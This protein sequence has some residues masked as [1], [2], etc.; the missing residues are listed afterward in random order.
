MCDRCDTPVTVTGGILDFTHGSP[1]ALT[2]PGEYDA[3]HQI[4]DERSAA[5]YRDL[6]RLA[7]ERW[8]TSL[9]SVLEVGCGTGLLTRGLVRGDDAIDLTATD[10]SLPMLLATRGHLERAGLLSNIPVT[11]AAHDGTEPVF[12]D[13]IFDTA[14]GTSVLHH[15]TDVRGFLA[16]VF[17]WLK[18]GGRAF[19]TEP[20]LRYHR[21]L[22]QTL[23]D[24]IAIM[25]RSDPEFSHGRQTLL[26]L[27][28]QWRQGILHQNDLPFLSGLD[29]KHMFASDKFEAMGREIGF[30][31]ALA[32]PVAYSPTGLGFVHRLCAQIGIGEPVR[33]SVLGLLPAYANRYM[34]LLSD[35][36]QTGSF[37]FWLEKGTGPAIRHFSGPPAPD[38]APPDDL[39]ESF[40][41]GG[42][43]PRWSLELTASRTENGV[44]VLLHGWCLVNTD[45]TWVR[46]ALNG[47]VRQTPV[48][49]PRPDV[50]EAINDAGLYASWNALC[51][52]VHE[53]LS[54]PDGAMDLAIQI[55]LAGGTVLHV[56]TPPQ[57]PLDEML[58][59][60][61]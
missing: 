50:Q 35:R 30:A 43:P 18:P 17:R 5:R 61:Q 34:S 54:F 44:A 51:S 52:G 3:R 32:I 12:R 42:L 39:P 55:V 29:D 26:N 2:T 23:A 58:I 37:L 16:N 45:V 22:G 57:L 6:K 15:I 47:A 8:P 14:V 20:N 40:R 7:G 10:I 49:L 31:T 4:D 24:I 60:T 28:G 46:V 19:F 21:A 11:F 27:V 1:A 59:V 41:T 53:T 9:G 36:D 13:N 48:W 33:S 38:A 56:P 25:Y